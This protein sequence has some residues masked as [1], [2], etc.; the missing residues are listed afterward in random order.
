MARMIARSV[1]KI[2]MKIMQQTWV[3]DNGQVL[4]FLRFGRHMV[5]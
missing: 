3:S 5:R 2:A 4:A 1:S